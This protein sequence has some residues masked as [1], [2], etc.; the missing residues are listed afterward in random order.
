MIKESL[1]KQ[2]YKIDYFLF[3]WV[4]RLA[5]RDFYRPK[6]SYILNIRLILRYVIL[7]KV[8]RFNGNVSW[9]VHFTSVIIGSKK[10]KKGIMCDPGD[11]P[12]CYIQGINGIYF[13]SN[14]EMGAGVKIISSNHEEDNYSK[15]KKSNPIIIGN[16]VWIGANSVILPEVKIGDNVIIG[17]GSIV[18]KNIPSNSVA[19]GNPCKVIR[20]KLRYSIDINSIEL[21]RKYVRK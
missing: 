16:N 9:P 5:Y 14:V 7:Q 20:E 6:Y 11:T 15:S 1:K 21:N 13:G 12:S 4:L 19:V 18:T 2:I 17:A 3:G 10:I 8:F